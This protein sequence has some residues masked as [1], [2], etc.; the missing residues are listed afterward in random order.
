LKQSPAAVFAKII[1]RDPD[2]VARVLA[3]NVQALVGG[4][5]DMQLVPRNGPEFAQ[6]F[7][8]RELYVFPIED[9][10]GTPFPSL[11]AFDLPA[12]VYSGGAFSLMGPEQIK[13]VLASGEIPEVLHDSVGEVANIICGA[14]VHMIRNR[15]AEAPQFR[16][17]AA[18][19]K[20]SV[21]AWPALLAEFGPRV[22]WEIV[23]CR[24]S[25]EGEGRG[26][27]FFAASDGQKGRVTKE[28]IIAVAGPGPEPESDAEQE[29]GDDI[30]LVAGGD[31]DEEAPSEPLPHAP[32][33]KLESREDDADDESMPARAPRL[34]EA[35]TGDALDGLRVLV[36]GHPADPAAAA[37]RSTLEGTGVRVLPAFTTPAQDGAPPD[38][39][40]VVS[41]SP[42]DLRIRLE[43]VPQG[44]RPPLVVACSDRPTRDLV[45]AARGAGA[46]DFLVLPTTVERL[47]GL[48]GRVPVSV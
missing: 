21:G 35:P 37:L 30:P 33:S 41:R 11:L 38:A 6:L 29:E 2:A 27:I 24:L 3:E 8:E 46:D 31:A 14:A 12:A 32:G 4:K 42:V 36:T 18:F 34:A 13:E 9:H 10:H 47:R 5:V 39:L 26:A 7:G 25:A 43:R 15:V 22:P 28:E 45:M 20:K 1:R 48:L 16:R 19:A 23:A 44:R 40:F 17:G